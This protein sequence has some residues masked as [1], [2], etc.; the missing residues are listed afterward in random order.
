MLYEDLI[1]PE[2]RAEYHRIRDEEVA[3]GLPPKDLERRY[4]RKD[5]GIFWGLRSI[6]R[7]QSEPDEPVHK[8]VMIQDITERKQAEDKIRFQ[9]EL[10]ESVE[11]AVIATDMAGAIIFWNRSAETTVRLAGVRKCSAARSAPSLPSIKSTV[12]SAR[13]RRELRFRRQLVGRVL[14]RAARWLDDS[15][16]RSRIRRVKTTTGNLIGIV[17]VATDVTEEKRAR[18]RSWRS[19]ASSAIL[20]RTAVKLNAESDLTALMQAVIDAGV[21]LTGAE[22]GA[23]F[24]GTHLARRRPFRAL[25][26]V[27]DQPRRAFEHAAA[28]A[29]GRGGRPDSPGQKASSAG[30]TSLVTR[31]YAEAIAARRSAVASA[32]CGATSRCRSSARSRKG[33][34]RALPRPQPG[35]GLHRAH[36]ADHRGHR[37][38]C[39]DR[40]SR[41]RACSR[42][43]SRKSRPARRSKS[44]STRAKRA[45]AISP[46]SDRTCCGRPTSGSA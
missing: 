4:L 36:R 32:W 11:Q 23:L 42:R 9:A 40:R 20:N 14:G 5:G 1:V 15:R 24:S 44:R 7:V 3:T 12:R 21:E 39:R 45:S 46:R 33:H 18:P 34:R 22:F 6:T 29:R 19:G 27:R 2:D 28:A 31:T 25:R 37:L 10:L 35:R 38:A 16:R 43:R 8:F 41:R 13:Y 30:T 26:G 17:A